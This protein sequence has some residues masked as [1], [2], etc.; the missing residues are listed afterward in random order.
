[1]KR[2]SPRPRPSGSALPESLSRLEALQRLLAVGRRQKPL[3]WY[4]SLALVCGLVLGF[5]VTRLV[6]VDAGPA[7]F[8]V[9]EGDPE[10]AR[11]FVSLVASSVATITSLTLTITVVTLQLASSQYSPRLIEHY[12][13][14]RGIRS[15]ISL[16]LLTFAFA[17]ATLLNVR[18]SG[19]EG[20]GEVPGPAISLLIL[21]V[22]A[23]LGALVFFVFR[24]TQSIRV[25]SI[26]ALVRDRTVAALESRHER[27]PDGDADDELPD[28]DPDGRLIRSRRTGFFVDLDRASMEELDTEDD[29]SVWVLVSP[30]DFVTSGAPVAIV[31]GWDAAD[32]DVR[33]V[34]E[35]WLRFDTERWIEADYS[36][37]VRS[38]TDVAVKALSPGINDPTT[39]VTAIQRIS[40]VM[41]AAA[42]SHPDR[43]MPVGRNGRA[44]V[45]V[46]TWEWTLH[47]VL[48]QLALYGRRDVHVVVGVVRMLWALHW[49]DSGVDRSEEVRAAAELYRELIDVDRPAPDQRV[50]DHYFGALR[51]SFDGDVVGE[52][53][54]NAPSFALGR[55][56]WASAAV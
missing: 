30:G 2:S 14:D 5:G 39:A 41:A 25:E 3:W 50:I 32:D 43:V 27:D 6:N 54:H 15:V 48:H 38:M 28:P 35:S 31:S 21:L 46:R 18:L 19:G 17:V 34:V 8:L 11:S 56:R 37:G 4:P 40:E 42:T 7:A 23:C 26:L 29:V 13:D 1:M 44:Y 47:E 51:R 10:S 49:V 53:R 36:Y 52:F 12:L 16:F 45:T 24:V 55:D 33:D 9:Y 20:S 22:V